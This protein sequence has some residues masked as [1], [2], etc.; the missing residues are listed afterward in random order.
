MVVCVVLSIPEFKRIL[1]ER[2]LLD[3]VISKL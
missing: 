2:R 3:I 1:V